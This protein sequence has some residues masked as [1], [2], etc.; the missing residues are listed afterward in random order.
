M[1]PDILFG[2]LLAAWGEPGVGRLLFRD[3]VGKDDVQQAQVVE[4]YY[5]R[6]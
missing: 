4:R 1:E 6:L 5:V 3:V 2:Y